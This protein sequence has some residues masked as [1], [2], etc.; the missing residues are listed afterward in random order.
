M[1]F[2]APCV[3][4]QHT[5]VI[6]LS[7]DSVIQ[8]PAMVHDLSSTYSPSSYMLV[9]VSSGYFIADAAD[10]IFSGYAKAS[11]EF[12][13]HHVLVLWCFLFS[14][15]TRRY[16]AGAVVA[17][18]VEVNSVF[19]HT[20]LLL[21]LAKVSHTSLILKAN[22]AL[23]FLTYVMFRLGA[24]FYITWFLI[25]H[26]S[27]LDFAFY[28]LTTMMLMNIMI[29]IYFYRLIRSDLLT[30]QRAQNGV[31]KLALD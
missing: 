19:L 20:R 6:V 24:Q 8:Y 18:F 1:T 22:K 29:L 21:N 25:Y 2:S 4:F 9:V 23:N 13:L 26:Y 5:C 28:F 30:R 17:L 31:C 10:I 11:W 3:S 14:V 12:L 15:F 7:P 27:S 16:V